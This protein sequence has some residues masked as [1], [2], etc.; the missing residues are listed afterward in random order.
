MGGEVG[1]LLAVLADRHPGQVGGGPDLPMRVRL[2]AAHQLALVLEHLH[3]G[4]RLSQRLGLGA[5]GVD[6]G[7]DLGGLQLG[8]TARVVGRET[9]HAAATAC[10]LGLQQRLAGQV[11]GLR[12]AGP[13]WSLSNT[14]GPQ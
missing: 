4:V 5:P 8:Q 12:A 9:D 11:G 2:R 3:P 6:E 1:A 13:G 14:Q 7:Q 10:R